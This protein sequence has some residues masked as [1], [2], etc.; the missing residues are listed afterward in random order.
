M[1]AIWDDNDDQIPRFLQQKVWQ[2]HHEDQFSDLVRRIRPG[3]QIAI[4]SSFVK[5]LVPFD[6][7]GKPVSVMRIKATGTVLENAGD[8]RTVK[9]D[10]DPPIEPRD[11]YFY[12]YRTTIEQAD[13]ETEG[14]RRLIDFTFR[15]VPQDYA[16]FLAQPYWL[17]KYGVNPETVSDDAPSA[18]VTWMTRKLRRRN[19]PTRLR[20]SW[21]MDAF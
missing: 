10:W 16:W 1:G 5:K 17:E 19:L 12:T 14:G 20:T 9:V 6:A 3:D 13:P 2:N 21:P 15:G 7:G 18:S 11:W 4:K 8:G